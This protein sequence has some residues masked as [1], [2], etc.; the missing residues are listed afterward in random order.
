MTKINKIVLTSI[1]TLL[2]VFGCTTETIIITEKEKTEIE[3]AK[4]TLI[5][6]DGCEYYERTEYKM[7]YLAH[8]GNCKNE[9]HNYR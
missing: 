4:Y 9:I 7:G 1:C 8:K 3:E 2:S 5:T 6:L